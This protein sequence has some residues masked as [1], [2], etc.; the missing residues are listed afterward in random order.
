MVFYNSFQIRPACL[1]GPSVENLGHLAEIAVDMSRSDCLQKRLIVSRS[2]PF[3]GISQ[4]IHLLPPH[5]AAR[6]L[7]LYDECNRF[8]DYEMMHELLIEL[9]CKTLVDFLGLGILGLTEASLNVITLMIE[10]NCIEPEI[11][12]DSIIPTI[13]DPLFESMVS[14]Q[15]RLK[16]SALRFIHAAVVRFDWSVF[17]NTAF[18][19]FI[20]TTTDYISNENETES[21]WFLDSL[22]AALRTQD[23]DFF[24]FVCHICDELDI[25]SMLEE[26]REMED[27]FIDQLFA[28]I[29]S[30]L[31]VREPKTLDSFLA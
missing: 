30:I 16:R 26:L 15:F 5:V 25:P 29:D 20:L 31:R 9:D 11:L 28:Y 22:L 12:V 19:H 6:F 10:R 2:H 14:E 13:I 21:F 17:P 27:P 4:V 1:E 8:C 18:E 24:D 3:I 7:F 23:V